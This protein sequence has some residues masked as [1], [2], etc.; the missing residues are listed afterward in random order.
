MRDRQHMRRCMNAHLRQVPDHLDEAK[1]TYEN[2]AGENKQQCQ[3]IHVLTLRVDAVHGS[4]G[5]V[6][7]H[8]SEGLAGSA[9]RPRSQA[10]RSTSA[11]SA[12]PF[13]SGSRFVQYSRWAC[14]RY[15]VA[16]TVSVAVG[17]CSNR[18]I[19]TMLF[20]VGPGGEVQDVD[21]LVQHAVAECKAPE[22]V[23]VQCTVPRIP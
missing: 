19:E 21:R 3:A 4:S 8:A 22:S 15:W 9:C 17:D 20:V 23:D 1:T 6:G 7:D 16:P 5:T 18:T 11:S 14:A 2:E 13:L 10:E 12:R